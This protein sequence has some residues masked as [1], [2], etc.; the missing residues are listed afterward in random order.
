[1]KQLLEQFIKIIEQSQGV[2]E[3]IDNNIKKYIEENKVQFEEA[4]HKIKDRWQEIINNLT[5]PKSLKEAMEKSMNLMYDFVGEEV[6][7]KL[8]N[9][10]K[11]FPFVSSYIQKLYPK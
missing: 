11:Q 9:I 5:K 3:K 6:M 2:R 7:T 10:Q 8:I 4:S 1:M